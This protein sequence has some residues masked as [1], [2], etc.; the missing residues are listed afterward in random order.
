MKKDKVLELLNNKFYCK[1]G[2]CKKEYIIKINCQ[3]KYAEAALLAI[4]KYKNNEITK[5]EF[6]NYITIITELELNSQSYRNK[7]KCS[8]KNCY[9]SVKK[10]LDYIIS[11]LKTNYKKPSIYKVDDY[12]KIMLIH[13]KE[14]ISNLL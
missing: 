10:Y 2:N 4:K 3:I 13:N 6:I 14:N 11:I 8:L 12:I 9:E 5:S 1:I 7:V